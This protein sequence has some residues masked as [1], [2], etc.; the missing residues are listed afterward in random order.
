MEV[1]ESVKFNVDSEQEMEDEE[2]DALED[3]EFDPA[4]LYMLS[5]E[6]ATEELATEGNVSPSIERKANSRKSLL[7][8]RNEKRLHF[9]VSVEQ[10]EVL[11]QLL[12]T[13]GFSEA[14]PTKA[15]TD[16]GLFSYE[17]E[18]SPSSPKFTNTLDGELLNRRIGIVYS[19]AESERK[20]PLSANVLKIKTMT[21]EN[22]CSSESCMYNRE[23]TE[24]MLRQVTLHSP[25]LTPPFRTILIDGSIRTKPK[26][27]TL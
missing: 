8:R 17:N 4:L 15:N 13:V 1:N 2:E 14:S 11:D 18:A 22:R 21:G 20:K 5:N 25:E 23:N 26:M 16:D 10:N 27:H 12:Q 24:A 9:G 19:M 7:D 6:G 3:E